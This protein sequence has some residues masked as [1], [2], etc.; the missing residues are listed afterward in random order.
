[1]PGVA[2]LREV[3]KTY[4]WFTAVGNV[5]WASISLLIIFDIMLQ[6]RLVIYEFVLMTAVVP[7]RWQIINMHCL[8]KS[9][10]GDVRPS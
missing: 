4:S 7:V 10:A 3:I 2:G 6:A 5:F 8:S 9:A 1:M